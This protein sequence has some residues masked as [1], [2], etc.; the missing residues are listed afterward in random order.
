MPKVMLKNAETWQT[1]NCATFANGCAGCICVLLWD[2]EQYQHNAVKKSQTELLDRQVP[3][4][5]EVICLHSSCA[6]S[7][8][9]ILEPSQSSLVHLDVQCY[10]FG[11]DAWSFSI[12]SCFL[13][14]QI[15]DGQPIPVD[16]VWTLRWREY[17]VS[18]RFRSTVCLYTP[19]G[20][21]KNRGTP[22][23]MVKIMENPHFLMD[24]LG[25]DR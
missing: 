20:V 18:L 12:I 21:S 15:E 2:Q 9:N 8:T 3:S 4:I 17:C 16:A 1:S 10:R 11:R 25:V 14:I 24:D 6:F 22:K 19:L 13:Q 5:H 23:C 7:V